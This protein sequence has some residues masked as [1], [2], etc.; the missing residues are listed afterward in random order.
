M[1][2]QKYLRKKVLLTDFQYKNSL[3]ED[4]LEYVDKHLYSTKKRIKTPQIVL[5]ILRDTQIR[6]KRSKKEFCISEWDV[7]LTAKRIRHIHFKEEIK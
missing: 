7:Y 1:R 3:F 5:E 2:S 6:K 4:L